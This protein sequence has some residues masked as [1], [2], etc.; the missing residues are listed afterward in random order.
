[1]QKI[2]ILGCG[3]LGLPLAK[4][5]LDEGYAVKGSTTSPE[6]ID[7]LKA[8]GIEPFKITLSTDGIAGEINHFLGS[9]ILIIDIPPK[10]AQGRF[11]DK[12]KTLLPCL[13]RSSIS[14]ILF[15]SSISVYAE[16]AGEVNEETPANPET[17]N[18]KQLLEAEAILRDN[19]HFRTTI[20]RFGGL[21]GNDRHPVKFL[22]G[23]EK[24]PNPDAPINLIDAEDCIG[25]ICRIIESGKW[26]ETYN[27]V[28]PF[29]PTRKT[30]YTQKAAEFDLP[31]PGFAQDNATGK[32]VSTQKITDELGYD[33]RKP[34]L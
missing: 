30:Y 1:M 12:I 7:L 22:A 2:S 29:H 13:E 14:Q 24:V 8:A 9:D 5:L 3:W 16:N 33:F 15:I 32:I 34:Q 23:R 18:G 26:G 17:E 11:T 4:K 20:L 10:A 25:I 28:A 19:I 27:A 31:A 6:K 21:V